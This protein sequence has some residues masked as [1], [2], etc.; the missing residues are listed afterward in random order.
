MQSE[1]ATI[2]SFAAPMCASHAQ[3]LLLGALDSYVQA[4]EQQIDA[5]SASGDYSA[6]TRQNSLF[7]AWV[8]WLGVS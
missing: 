8:Y 2:A 5:R 4:L 1:R 3:T 6:Y 7:L